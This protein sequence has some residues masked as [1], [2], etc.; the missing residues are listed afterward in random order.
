MVVPLIAVLINIF[1]LGNA[2]LDFGPMHEATG[3]SGL[4]TSVMVLSLQVPLFTNAMG[5]VLLAKKHR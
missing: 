3:F 1:I 2:P 5:M 4:D